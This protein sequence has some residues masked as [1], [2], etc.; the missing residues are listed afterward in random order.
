MNLSAPGT[1]DEGSPTRPTR[2]EWVD[3]SR[4]Q[5][6]KVID[7]VSDSQLSSASDGDLSE[8]LERA[9]TSDFPSA[10]RCYTAKFAGMSALRGVRKS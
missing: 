1:I 7:V 4:W 10:A 5:A 6:V 2:S 3:T 9:E 8:L